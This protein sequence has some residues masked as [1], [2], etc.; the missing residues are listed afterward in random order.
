M[1]KHDNDRDRGSSIGGA[2]ELSQ[3]LKNHTQQDPQRFAGLA[4]QITPTT[5]PAYPSAILWG[6]GEATIPPIAQSAIFDAIR[7]IM[8]LGIT[9]CDR[10]LG[11]SVRRLLVETPLDIVELVRDRSQHAPDPKDNSP[12]FTPQQEERRGRD[13]RQHGINTARGSLVE[14]LGDLLVHDV[15]GERTATVSPHL[16]TL[17]SDPVLSVR[18]C[19][20]HTIAACLRHARPTAYEAF[21]RLIAANDILLASDHVVNLMMYIGNVDPNRIDPLIDRMLGSGNGEVR[22]AGGSMAAF[23]ALQWDRPQLMERALAGT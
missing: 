18:S 15:H 6:F 13:L 16:V 1:A 4:M 10:W 2:H 9:E 21:E 5:N 7:H 19:V 20:A 12:V 17:A 22:Q 3:T 11:W 23:A 14:E 8:S